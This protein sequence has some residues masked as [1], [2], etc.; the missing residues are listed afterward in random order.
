MPAP[1]ACPRCSAPNALQGVFCANC[2]LYLRDASMTV[3]RVT[4]TRRIFG[5]W[6]LEGVLFALTLVIG[7]FIWLFFSAKKAQSPA[8]SLTSI[9]IVNLETGRAASAGEVWLRDVVLK[10]IVANLVG[11]GQVVDLV[12]ALFDRDRQTLHDKVVKTVVVYAPAG[13]PEA[14][15]YQ[16]GAP[17]RY[18][19]PPL[20][21]QNPPATT[22]SDIGEQLR[23]LQ[24]LHQENLLSDE[25]YERKRSDLVS[26]L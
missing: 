4:Y 1:S 21:S 26:K 3:E 14:M 9:Y 13:L 17:V 8:K 6:L 25:E 19:A 2:N 18:Q 22:V 16:A 23:E 20:F 10:I 15:Q 7:W 24:R 12:W 5:S 11:V